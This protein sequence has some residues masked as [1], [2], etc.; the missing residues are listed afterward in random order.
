[1]NNR[2]SEYATSGAFTMSLT[3]NQ[4][5]SL[6]MLDGGLPQWGSTAIAGLERKGLAEPI[7]DPDIDC[8]ERIEYRA[9]LAGLLTA[10]LCKEAGLTNGAADPVA[11]ELADLKAKLEFAR[12]DAVEARRVARSA[13]ARKDELELELQNERARNRR[14][15]MAVRV[16]LRDPKPEASD[17]ELRAFAEASV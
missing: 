14:D 2:F 17:A 11:S 16:L 15:K 13:L 6:A 7:A 8:P 10:R 1:M 4:V 5:S 9:T 12:E 3:R